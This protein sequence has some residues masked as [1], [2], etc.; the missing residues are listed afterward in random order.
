MGK[1]LT[2]ELSC[3]VTGLVL[4]SYKLS[5]ELPRNKQVFPRELVHY[6]HMIHIEFM[7]DW[8]DFP[9]E[10]FWFSHMTMVNSNHRSSLCQ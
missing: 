7:G 8:D 3:P 9:M 6:Y 2:Q 5:K 4:S 1:V 10:K